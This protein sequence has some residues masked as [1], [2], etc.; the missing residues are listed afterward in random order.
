MKKVGKPVFFIVAVLIALLTYTAFFGISTSFGDNTTTIIKGADQ[1]RWGIDI[2]GGVDVTFTPPEGVDATDEQM[3]AAQ[4][5]IEQRLVSQ[6]ITDSEVYTDFQKDRVIVRFPWKENEVDFNPEQAIKELGETALLT[7]REGIELD[8]DGMPTGV[9]AENIILTG[10]DVKEARVAFD[11]QTGEALVQLELNDSG[12]ASFAEATRK[13]YPSKGVISIWMDD[14]VI[15]Y[16]TVNAEISDG[17]AVIQGS[18][19]ADSAKAL[20]DRINAGALPFKLETQNYNSID[21]TL[22]AGAKDAMILAGFI[23]FALISVYMIVIYR[24]QGVVAVIALVGQAAGMI[25][26]ITGY[27]PVF[28]SFTLTLPGIAG[29][30][31]SIGIGVDANV[32]T[33]ERVREELRLG[34]TVQGSIEVGF[35]RGFTAIL[36]SNLTVILVAIILMGAFGPPSSIMAT[37]YNKIF[38]FF[39]SATTGSVYSFGYTLLVGIILNFIFGVTA[40]RLMLRSLTNFKAFGKPALFGGVK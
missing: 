31:L 5:I 32:L 34:K 28:P 7:F 30:I 38:F 22:G 4:A 18:F 23:A 19:T 6:N 17:S 37:I 40:S 35:K 3:S 21:P 29:I 2:R 11:Q 33:A 15:S 25:A 26:A 16:P 20:A 10:A 8:A 39:G 9:T 1:I 13:L 24:I 14:T 36:D 12:K 27:F